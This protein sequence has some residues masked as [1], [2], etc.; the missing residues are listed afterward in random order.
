[1]SDMIVYT[2]ITEPGG[3]DGK[4]PT[5][6]GGLMV[7]ATFDKEQAQQHVGNDSRLKVV[8]VV[9]DPEEVLTDILAKLTPIERLFHK[10]EPQRP[11]VKRVPHDGR[12]PG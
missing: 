2:V 8:P 9:V 10:F 6:K 5:D 11:P 7:R 1:M 4:D 3:V 12:G